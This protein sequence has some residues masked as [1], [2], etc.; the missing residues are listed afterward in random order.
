MLIIIAMMP[1]LFG[2]IGVR[3]RVTYKSF[4]DEWSKIKHP[5]VFRRDVS[6]DLAI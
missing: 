3:Q 1:E 5:A 4:V 6:I 2:N